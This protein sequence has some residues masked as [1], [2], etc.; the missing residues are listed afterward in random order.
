MASKT[1]AILAPVPPLDPVTLVSELVQLKVAPAGTE[2]NAM[3]V[4]V[5][6]QIVCNAGVAVAIGF[7]FTLTTTAIGEPIHPFKV[8]VTLYVTVPVLLLVVFKTCA[9]FEPAPADEPVAKD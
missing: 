5:P 1:C 8:G 4:D 6:S 9:M 3:P 2:L 7:G